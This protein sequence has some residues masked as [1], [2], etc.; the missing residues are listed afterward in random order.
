ME[1][2]GQ[3]HIPGTGK[4]KILQFGEGNFLR[5][6]VDWMVDITN[7]K[8]GF[9]GSVVI[10][11]PLDKGLSEMI[12]AQKGMYTT[13]LRGIQNGKPVDERRTITSVSR[14]INPY[15]EYPTYL[16]CAKLE[17]LRFIVSNTTEAG[18]AYSASDTLSDQPPASYP[19]KIT[20]FL[21]E[22]F[23]YFQGKADKGLVVICC[24][25]IDKNA[26]KLHEI[27]LR[28]A[29]E[30][31][32]GQAFITW[33]EYSC[34]FLNSLVDRIVTGYPRDEAKQ[35]ESEL[36]YTDNLLDTAEIFHLWVIE[37]QKDYSAEFPLT[38]AGLNVVWTK[39]MTPYR[40]QKVRVLNG[41]HTMTV[42]AAYL[43]GLDTVGQCMDDPVISAYMKK[44]IYTEVIPSVH[45]DRNR[46]EN[47]AAAVAERFANPYIKHLLLNISL[48]SV[49]KFRTRVL[50]SLI[51]YY[52][53]H[54][55]LPAVL[56]F[57]L[58]ALIAFY[59]G[60]QIV[61]GALIGTRGE[62]TYQ[63]KDDLPVLQQFANEW[64][65]WDGS[66]QATLRLVG[67]VLGESSW[68]GSDLREVDGLQY[69]VASTL[70]SILTLGVRKTMEG[71]V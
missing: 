54:H 42:L 11:Q 23:R 63:I 61:D 55:R 1:S 37:S 24:E 40:T 32:L 12:N 3:T 68:W 30:W 39:D 65:E 34:D 16:D 46:L 35:I 62:Q 22:R 28:L 45:G 5:G 17:Q 70:E 8:T 36:G 71:L 67:H 66:A 52:L 14:C 15:S 43:A 20:Q 69:A 59:R 58:A 2:I 47:Y 64:K 13:I 29:K 50:P 19:G 56:T 27:V 33:V 57:S 7:E 53:D 21:Y 41:A 10:V 4:E 48:N 51:G 44:G 60:T 6:F 18:I 31:N 26:T 9:D 49:S 38:Q 25:L